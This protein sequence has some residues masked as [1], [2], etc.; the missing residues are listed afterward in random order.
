MPHVD[1]LFNQLQKRKT[2][3][4]QVKTA[5]DNFEKCIVDVRNKIDDI[6]NEA[7]SIC[8]EP[9]GNKRRRRN[10]SSHDHRVAALEVCD[11]IVD[12][13]NDRFQFKDHLVA[14]SPF[15]PN[16]L[17]NTVVSFLLTTT[18]LAYPE[19]EKSRLKTELSVIYAR[20]D[21]RD[22]HGTLSLLKFLIQNSL[23]ETLKETKK[24]LV[25]IVTTLVDVLWGFDLSSSKIRHQR[26]WRR[27]PL[28]G[29]WTESVIEIHELGIPPLDGAVKPN[30][31]CVSL[32]TCHA[33]LGIS[34]IDGVKTSSVIRHWT[35]VIDGLG[36]SRIDGAD[37]FGAVQTKRNLCVI[38]QL[39]LMGWASR[40]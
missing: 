38:G 6:I 18:C 33:S 27:A 12:S 13:A 4:A 10:N 32:D 9:Q 37:L 29:C 24:L 14:A 21:C 2:E 28:T 11:N 35:P 23:G 7:K 3:P 34:R 30:G 39:P 31:I 17:K 25:I 1:I 22:L 26:R 19:L 40:A 36:I 20:N 8:T 15:S 5:I 16:T